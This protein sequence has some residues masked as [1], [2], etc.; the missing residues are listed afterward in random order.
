[1]HQTTGPF[2]QI[3]DTRHVVR[4]TA[5]VTRLTVRIPDTAYMMH[6]PH[7]HVQ[8]LQSSEKRKEKK[9]VS[10]SELVSFRIFTPRQPLIGSSQ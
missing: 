9:A 8:K 7:R 10:L 3:P 5:H 2:R 6:I 4:D 1:M